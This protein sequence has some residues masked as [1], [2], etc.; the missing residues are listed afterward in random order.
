MQD[1]WPAHG[2]TSTDH[3]QPGV[4]KEQ[5]QAV[6]RQVM[7][8]KQQHCQ[9]ARAYGELAGICDCSCRAVFLCV[10]LITESQNYAQGEV[11]APA[12]TSSLPPSQGAVVPGAKP[13][14]WAQR[15]AWRCLEHSP[16]PF[17]P[18]SS[19]IAPKL[20]DDKWQC[21]HTFQMFACCPR[22]QMVSGSIPWKAGARHTGC[23]AGGE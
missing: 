9:A 21:C 1:V 13:H 23:S 16:C 18:P 4:P 15:G 20:A 3:H 11:T 10:K 6:P 14:S 7:L 5:G 17:S 12:V 8:H 19:A 22:A 2:S